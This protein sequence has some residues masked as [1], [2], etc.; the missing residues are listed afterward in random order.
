MTEPTI[1]DRVDR[2]VA[3][4][5]AVDGVV[6]LHSGLGVP[7]TYLPG[8]TIGGVRLNSDG[9]QVHVVLELRGVL[10]ETAEKVRQAATSAAG[11]PVDV[12]VGDVVAVTGSTK[13]TR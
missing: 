10:L 9:G 11:V 7:A 5:T 8:R 6:G 4:V 12:V 3:A 2:V 1:G 13:R